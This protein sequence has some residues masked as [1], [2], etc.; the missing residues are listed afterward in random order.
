MNQFELRRATDADR[1]PL[2][3][4]LELYQHDI[5]DIWDQD[6]DASGRYGYA[7]D[8]YWANPACLP[9]VF[10]QAGKY[11]GFALLNDSV[12]LPENDIWLAQFFVMKKYRRQGTGRQAALALFE[13]VRGRWEVGQMPGN[14]AALAFWRRVIGEYTQGAFV[15]H[16]LDDER[17]HGTLQCFCNAPGEFS[18]FSTPPQTP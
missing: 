7:L 10:L 5:S 18:P 3:Q 11:A 13:S 14:L 15:E 4:M 12:S 16:E 8:K 2:Q 6:L 17:W 9:F 1:A